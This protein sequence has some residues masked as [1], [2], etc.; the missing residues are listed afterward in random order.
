M[1]YMEIKISEIKIG[2]R[3]RKDPGD[4]TSLAESIK[5]IG[6]LHPIVVAPD[7]TLIAGGRRIAAFEALGRATIPA[8]VL[9]DLDEL[10]AVL[11]AERDEN[12]QRLDLVPSEAVSMGLEIER[13]ASEEAR[14]RQ[15]LGKSPDGQAGG[16]GHRNLGP[17]LGHR[18]TGRASGVAAKAVGMSRATYEKA[19]AITLSG[20]QKLLARM[21]Q[22]GKIAGLYKELQRQQAA[23][24][25]VKQSTLLPPEFRIEHCDLRELEIPLG[26]VDLILTDPPYDH[27]S[28]PL[29]GV[30]AE[31]TAQWLKPGGIC[32]AYA[33]QLYLSEIIKLMREHLEW[34]WCFSVVHRGPVLTIRTTN[35]RQCWKPVLAFVKPPL[36]PWWRAFQDLVTTGKQEKT[37]HPWQQAQAESDYFIEHLAPAGGLV[38]DPF[39]G[40]GTVAVAAA[41]LGRGFVGCDM[42]EEAVE[43]ARG[44]VGSLGVK[45]A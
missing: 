10:D 33:G 15:L 30:L 31:R 35:F 38:V 42:E 22:T 37:L 1:K 36:H 28:V 4:I 27:D 3:H 12:I 40:G 32:L 26:T 8:T 44:R 39:V 14:A 5:S 16:R 13:L 9:D 43:V 2:H 20:N 21:D 24:V 11:R 18:F 25:L 34:L 19:K 41:R 6:L 29:Y 7:G 23:A 17:K 45:S